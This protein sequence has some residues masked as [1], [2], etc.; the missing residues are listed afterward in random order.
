M[1]SAAHQSLPCG[2]SSF[3]SYWQVSH[4][5][6]CHDDW[7]A[8]CGHTT[9]SSV[10]SPNDRVVREPEGAPAMKECSPERH[11][12]IFWLVGMRLI[13]DTTALSGAGDY[14]DFKIHDG[15]HVTVWAELEKRCACHSSKHRTPA[16]SMTWHQARLTTF[17]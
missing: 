4:I 5:S 7:A 9:T 8:R 13:S 16:I 1:E 10:D 2:F 6:I 17:R 3:D 12:G 15:D 14:G 11:V